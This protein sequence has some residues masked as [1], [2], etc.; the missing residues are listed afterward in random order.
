MTEVFLRLPKV[1]LVDDYHEFNHLED[2]LRSLT[3][4]NRVKV[5]ELG[6][7][8]SRPRGNR[9]VGIVYTRK[10]AYYRRV[11]REAKKCYQIES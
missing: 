2:Q 8:N 3:G 10:D 6:L 7:E 9:Y 1:V 4:S 11:V 5:A